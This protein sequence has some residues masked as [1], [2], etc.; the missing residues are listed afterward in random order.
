MYKREI[1]DLKIRL[2]NGEN[3]FN[4][5][6]YAIYKQKS[7]LE[8]I[9]KKFKDDIITGSFALSLYGLAPR[10]PMHDID[11]IIENENRYSNYKQFRYDIF[12]KDRLGYLTFKSV[13][14]LFSKSYEIDFFKKNRGDCFNILPDWDL[15]IHSPLQIIKHKADMSDRSPKH[16]ADLYFIFY[17]IKLGN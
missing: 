6:D 8:F 7:T 4:F 1:R 12:L 13:K 3:I 2:L 10:T 17:D 5:D 9:S 11:I 15:K 16:S 14:T